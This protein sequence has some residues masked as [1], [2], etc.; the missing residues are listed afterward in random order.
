MTEARNIVSKAEGSSLLRRV[1][2]SPDRIAELMA[3][4]PDPFDVDQQ[5]PVLARFG[6]TRGLLMEML[7]GSP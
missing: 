6:V 1:G 2:M 4:L 3:Q 5:E 7:G